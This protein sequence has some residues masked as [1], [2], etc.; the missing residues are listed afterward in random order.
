M[1][2][3]A[4][5]VAVGIAL[6]AASAAFAAGPWPGTYAWFSG[7]SAAG[8]GRLGS[9]LSAFSNG[10]FNIHAHHLR[11]EAE[12]GNVELE[13]GKQAEATTL[14]PYDIGTPNRKPLQIGWPDGEDVMPLIIAGNAVQKSDLQQWRSGGKTVAAIN[15]HGG[16]RL[17]QVT[18]TATVKNGRV[19][20]V[21][22][23]PNGKE[24]TLR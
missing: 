20:L 4:V 17:G 3:F 6:S 18:L 13:S 12:D 16:L 22:T 23:L 10:D 21:A 15:A 24:Q 11:V 19:V 9:A 5:G 7:D 1:K 2:K 14:N 8:I